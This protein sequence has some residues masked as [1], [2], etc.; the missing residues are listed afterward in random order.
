MSMNY[1]ALGRYT[2]A[3]N[4]VRSLLALRH[5][6]AN[7]LEGLLRGAKM[8]VCG[9]GDAVQPFD[10]AEAARKLD[11]LT[12]ANIALEQAILDA[13]FYAPEAGET[14]VRRSNAR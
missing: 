1:E 8:F 10:H 13:D 14:K 7:E 9:S 2:D 11:A 6:L 4:R 3:M 5:N 12:G